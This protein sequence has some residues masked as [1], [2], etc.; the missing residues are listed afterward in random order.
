MKK[1]IKPV[2]VLLMNIAVGFVDFL[3]KLQTKLLPPQFVLLKYAIGNVVTNRSIYVAAE[4]GIADLLKDGPKTI[5]QLAKETDTNADTL[6]RIM[7][8]LTGAGIFKAKKNRLFETNNLGT[9]LRTDLEDSMVSFIK[10]AGSEWVNDIWGGLLKT[11]K[12]GKDFY[13]NKYG[14]NFFEWLRDNSEAQRVFDEG[15]TSVSALSDIPVSKAYDFSSFKT[16]VDV[17]GGYGSQMI[18]ILNTCPHLKAFI[19]DLPLTIKI[20]NEDNIIKQSDL[21]GK[22][23]CIAGDFFESVP[24]GYD[25]YFMKSILHDWEDEKAV[26]ILTNCRK[27]MRNDSKLLIVEN[28]L[29]DDENAPDFSKVLD[30]NVLALMGGRVRTKTEYGQIL[31]ASGLKLTRVI[32]TASPFSIIEAKPI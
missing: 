12:T 26:K 32:P 22:L 25:A 4:L 19:Y 29:K 23:E 6:Y 24:A 16:L 27:A 1:L 13:E 21:D 14:M 5:E 8:T 10:V 2:Q 9:H 3:G 31:D 28:V 7:R 17:G 11:T 15:M 30:I 20:I 18:T